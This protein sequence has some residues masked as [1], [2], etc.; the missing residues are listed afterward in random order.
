MSYQTFIEVTAAIE[1]AEMRRCQ[2]REHGCEHQR[3]SLTDDVEGFFVLSR[4]IIADHYTLKDERAEIRRCQNREQVVNIQG[5]LRRMMW[6]G[7][8][9]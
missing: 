8:L 1:S 3:A 7:S 4:R 6:K 5:H 9:H 2:N